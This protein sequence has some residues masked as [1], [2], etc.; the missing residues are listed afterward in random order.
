MLVVRYRTTPGYV[1]SFLV[2]RRTTEGEDDQQY[3][4]TAKG[5]AVCEEES[6]DEDEQEEAATHA[7][8]TDEAGGEC[9]GAGGEKRFCVIVGCLLVISSMSSY[10]RIVVL[11]IPKSGKS[12]LFQ[13]II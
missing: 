2:I 12:T 5:T 3:D 10:P 4:Q 7:E 6:Q 9:D 13:G 11:S 1:S 8:A